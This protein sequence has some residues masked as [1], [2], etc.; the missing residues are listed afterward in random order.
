VRSIRLPDEAVLT[1][2]LDRKLL[3]G[4]VVIGGAGL[5]ASPAGWKDR[6]YRPLSGKR[7]KVRVKAVPY[8]LWDNRAPGAMAVWLPRA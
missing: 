5:A 6:L 4:A 3:G 2:R 7:R 8:C 1:A